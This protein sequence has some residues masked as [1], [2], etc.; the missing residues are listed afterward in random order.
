MI[1]GL[2]G[3]L[4]ALTACGAQRS[5]ASIVEASEFRLLDGWRMRARL[6]MEGGAPV[7]ALLDEAGRAALRSELDGKGRP[8]ITLFS[9][10]PTPRPIAVLE[11]DDKG[12]HVLFHGTG[13]QESYLFQKN[14]GTAGLV[15]TNS[16][17]AHRAEVKL[18]ASGI[19]DISLFD[20]TGKPTFQVSVSADGHIR[21]GSSQP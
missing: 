5:Q 1:R 7:F 11:G 16:A 14:D 9:N 12:A 17:G 18:D 20:D 13:A 6:A 3:M 10:E 15:L 2:V 21:Q 4:M 8:R 19:V